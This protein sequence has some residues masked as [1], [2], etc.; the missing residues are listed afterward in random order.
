[1]NLPDVVMLDFVDFQINK[2]E[3]AEDAV[4]EDEVHPVVSVVEG[5]AVFLPTKVKPL[6]S[7]KRKG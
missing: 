1:M 6:P 5:D 7:S 2:D 3:A 4:V